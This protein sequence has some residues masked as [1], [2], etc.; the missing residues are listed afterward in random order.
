MFDVHVS[1]LFTHP[2][3]TMLASYTARNLHVLTRIPT[4]D[5]YPV[6]KNL[7]ASLHATAT[8]TRTITMRV[9]L[10]WQPPCAAHSSLMAVSTIDRHVYNHVILN[11]VY[12]LE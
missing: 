5:R 9:N 4:Q 1:R 2:T 8:S 10:R 12:C 3:M 11:N 6:H 7:L